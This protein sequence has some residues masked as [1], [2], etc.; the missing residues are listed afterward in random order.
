M[1]ELPPNCLTAER[2]NVSDDSTVESL[3][4]VESYSDDS[5]SFIYSDQSS[6]VEINIEPTYLL[7]DNLDWDQESIISEG[8]KKRRKRIEGSPERGLD[9]ISYENF[10]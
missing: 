1:E 3:A 8:E 9:G 4:E 5:Y 6:Y 2:G 7:S 10:E